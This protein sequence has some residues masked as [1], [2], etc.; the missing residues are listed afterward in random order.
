M[1]AFKDSSG[2]SW[3]V[4]INV[5]TVKR[6]RALV[7][8][9]LYAVLDDNAK[10]LGEL[11]ADPVKFVDVL[12]VVCKPEADAT[13]VT[14]EAFGTS[15]GGDALLEAADTFVEALVDFFPQAR[16]RE[17]LRKLIAAGKTIRKII[18]GKAEAEAQKIGTIDLEAVAEKLID[19]F[20]NSRASSG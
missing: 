12:Y 6:V 2:R 7:S 20:T 9:D 18:A 4:A 19:S 1:H 15:L 5:A 11:L 13:G 10:P 8:V 17:A 16:A 3:T 14:D